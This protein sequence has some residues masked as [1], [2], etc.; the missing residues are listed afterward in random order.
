MNGLTSDKEAKLSIN[1]KNFTAIINIE[2][3]IKIEEGMRENIIQKDSKENNIRKIENIKDKREDSNN[4]ISLDL[5][6][7]EMKIEINN[8]Q[9]TMKKEILEINNNKK[10]IINTMTDNTTKI[11]NKINIK[12]IQMIFKKEKV[13]KKLK[14]KKKK[15]N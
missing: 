6:E 15:R 4:N 5:I 9:K 12:V 14:F 11:I 3:I 2:T 10:D 13:K 8:R 7:I 1:R